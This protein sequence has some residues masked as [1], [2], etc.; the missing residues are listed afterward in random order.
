MRNEPTARPGA[1]R[2]ARAA[3]AWTLLAGLGAT[4]VGD[5][6]AAARPAKRPPGMTAVEADTLLRYYAKDRAETMKWLKG[7]PTSYLATVQRQDFGER[8]SL[9]VGS[10]PGND[11]RIEDPDVKPR[12]LRVSC[13]WTG[14][15][16]SRSW[17]AS[18]AWEWRRPTM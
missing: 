1:R 16:C 11:M 5:A 13:R 7:S 10:A 17:W 12:H 18:F 6:A 15:T 3:L 8:S 2:V 14:R 4:Q 9:T